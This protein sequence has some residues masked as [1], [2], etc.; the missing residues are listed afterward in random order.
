MNY[1]A[2][3]LPLL[4]LS[5]TA[6]ADEGSAAPDPKTDAAKPAE[7]NVEVENPENL[8][9]IR[10]VV[11]PSFMVEYVTEAK[12]EALITGIGMFTGAPSDASI[13]LVGADPEKFVGITDRLYE[14][15]VA[16]LARA[17]VEVVSLDELKA[18]ATFQELAAKGQPAPREEEAKGG[19]GIYHSAKALPLYYMDE[20]NF[21]PKFQLKLFNKPKEDL[22]LSWGTKFGAGFATAGIPQLEERLA[23]EFNAAVMKVRI[24]ILGGAVAASHDFW[25][26]GSVSVKGAGAFAPMVT[27]FAFI[28]DNGDKARLSLKEPVNTGELGEL[29]NTTSAASKAG[30]VARNTI[31]VASRLLPVLTGGRVGRG[32]DLGYGNTANY[33][34][35]VEPGAFESEVESHYPAIA[36]LFVGRMDQPVAPAAASGQA[37]PAN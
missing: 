37:A 20:V 33:E 23:K 2:V 14:Q 18:S 28:K 26:G 30:D 15:T 5:A 36:G 3:C 9:G 4:F 25:T 22:F 6:R 13:K 21:I 27:R 19:K 10:R 35:R 16:Q 29:V 34:W 17:G 1:L 24:T 31:T 7:L 11:I 32:V 8:K 12:A